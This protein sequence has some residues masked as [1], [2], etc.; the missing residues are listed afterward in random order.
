MFGYVAH[1]LTAEQTPYR[2]SSDK[3]V[4]PRVAVNGPTSGGMSGNFNKSS[5]LIFQLIFS[6]ESTLFY[7]MR[8]EPMSTANLASRAVIYMVFM[9]SQDGAR[10]GIVIVL[11]QWST[12]TRL[13]GLSLICWACKHLSRP[14]LVKG[15]NFR[16]RTLPV[17]SLTSVTKKSSLQNV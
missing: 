13:N 6:C 10:S 8:C 17:N 16:E 14:R 15:Q 7:S 12:P 1:C 9:S 5:E 4:Y 2:A 3:R 11:F